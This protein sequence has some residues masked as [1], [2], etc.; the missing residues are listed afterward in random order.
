MCVCVSLSIYEEFQICLL[1]PNDWL[2]H[3]E[4]LCDWLF[5]SF[6]DLPVDLN[7]TFTCL[8][9]S[10]PGQSVGPHTHT[11]TQTLIHTHTHTDTHTHTHTVVSVGSGSVL[12]V[13]G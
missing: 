6:T 7:C 8:S 13:S 9:P 12:I 5:R 3:Q 10:A 1:K 4:Q 11:H 2:I